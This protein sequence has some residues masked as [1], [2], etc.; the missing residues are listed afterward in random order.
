MHVIGSKKLMLDAPPLI[1]FDIDIAGLFKVKGLKGERYFLTITCRGSRAIWLYALK[2]KADAYD[3]L[4]DFCNMINNQFNSQNSVKYKFMANIKAFKLDNAGEFKS[5]K[6]THYCKQKGYICEYTSPYS[7]SQNG[8]AERLN[9]YLIERLISVCKA[10][11][12]PLFLW[13][14]LLQGI[15]HIKNRL[16]NSVIKK[17]LFE[18]LCGKLPIIDYI[19][20]LSSLT[21]V[22]KN[23]RA[24]KLAD[25]S[26]RGILVGFESSN[27]YLVYL[28]SKRA[29]IS[30]KNV[31][32]KED[33]ILKDDM[34][35]ETDIFDY[36]NIVETLKEFK[37]ASDDIIK[38]I[39]SINDEMPNKGN[40]SEKSPIDQL[41]GEKT[42]FEDES[43]L[44]APELPQTPKANKKPNTTSPEMPK[45]PIKRPRKDYSSWKPNVVTRNA[46]TSAKDSNSSE[47]QLVIYLSFKTTIRQLNN[48]LIE[49]EKE[50]FSV[51]KDAKRLAFIAL[52]SSK[53]DED[54]D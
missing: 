50:A 36:D 17:T 4:I 47:N 53:I 8:I 29:V 51:Y 10:K 23:K 42:D 46:S 37:G 33:L 14:Y 24:H 30:S 12:L 25:K 40:I 15:A 18:A 43:D 26:D 22:L 13:P 9:K 7:P 52:I 48:W 45:A 28:P 44:F 2:L 54:F 32:I 31:L 35:E 5:N 16:Y 11:R 41:E 38:L 3:V 6:W 27:N 49:E 20:I 39:S 19:R 34:T 21:Y 1:I